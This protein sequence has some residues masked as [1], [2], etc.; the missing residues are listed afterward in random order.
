MLVASRLEGGDS[1]S[2]P[3]AQCRGRTALLAAA[4]RSVGI[5]PLQAE[6]QVLASH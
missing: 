2:E 1:Q 4:A 3:A 5:H 6:R